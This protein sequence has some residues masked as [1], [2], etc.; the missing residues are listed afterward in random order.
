MIPIQPLPKIR[1]MPP[2]LPRMVPKDHRV[3]VHG[4][5]Q[6]YIQYYD[7]YRSSRVGAFHSS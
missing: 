1:M 4:H 6:C 7:L 5:K 3:R 2:P